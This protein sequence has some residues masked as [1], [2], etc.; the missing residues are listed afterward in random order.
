MT[1]LI[2]I[3]NL[4]TDQW[5]KGLTRQEFADFVLGKYKTDFAK[6]FNPGI[7][8]VQYEYHT[9]DGVFYQGY[10][11]V[12]SGDPETVISDIDVSAN[13]QILKDIW[14]KPLEIDTNEMSTA[15]VNKRLMVC[16]RHEIKKDLL[17]ASDELRELAD[18]F[19]LGKTIDEPKVAFLWLRIKA[20]LKFIGGEWPDQSFPKRK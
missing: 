18:D 19:S 10:V 7:H 13:Q 8:E 17:K 6:E 11:L 20:A 5:L 2:N 3:F 12:A 9:K 1:E 14:D 15:E 16:T 4:K